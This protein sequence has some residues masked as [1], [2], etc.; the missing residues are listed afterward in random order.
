[1]GP[2]GRRESATGSA[3]EWK[4]ALRDAEAGRIARGPARAYRD[5]IA[6]APDTHDAQHMLG[7]IELGLGKIWTRRT[8]L[9][10]AAMAHAAAVSGHPPQLGAPQEARFARGEAC[11][12]RLAEAALPIL[13]ELALGPDAASAGGVQQGVDGECATGVRPLDRPRPWR[14]S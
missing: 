2:S 3:R 13:A 4:Q 6:A 8:R 11:R 10:S 7:I 1:M 12:S 14:R 5:V 9:I